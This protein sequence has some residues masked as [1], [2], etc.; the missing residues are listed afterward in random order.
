MHNE[1]LDGVPVYEPLRVKDR[2]R[3]LRFKP[4]V[5]NWFAL[6]DRGEEQAEEIEESEDFWEYFPEERKVRRVHVQER[7]MGILP[8]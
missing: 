3:E 6:C 8:E 1:R 4:Y 5:N 2:L 7:K